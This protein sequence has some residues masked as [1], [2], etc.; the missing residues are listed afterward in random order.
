MAW[1]FNGDY[2]ILQL[3]LVLYVCLFPPLFDNLTS[4]PLFQSVL[5]MLHTVS[6]PYALMKVNPLS[7][8]QKVCQYKGTKCTYLFL[9]PWNE[10]RAHTLV[11]F[12]VLYLIKIKFLI[13]E[14]K[15]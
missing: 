6:V 5:N 4:C 14:L 10:P 13:S 8:V 11:P 1:R 15:F 9:L 12:C 7:W 3:N 2:I